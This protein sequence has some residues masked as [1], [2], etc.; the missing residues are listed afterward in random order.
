MRRPFINQK[1][2]YV[3]SAHKQ[4]TTLLVHVV[5]FIGFLAHATLDFNIVLRL[6]F[7]QTFILTS[8]VASLEL[9][10]LPIIKLSL[11]YRNV[12]LSCQMMADKISLGAIYKLSNTKTE[13]FRPLT[14]RPLAWVYF[15][16]SMNHL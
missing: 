8:A 4:I 2:K 15:Q 1:V 3:A 13:I 12:S 11:H 9:K 7:S 10:F 14:H 6:S 5:C 16:P